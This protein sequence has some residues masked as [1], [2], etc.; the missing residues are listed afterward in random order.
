[1]TTKLCLVFLY[2]LPKFLLVFIAN[3][4]TDSFCFFF[5]F[6]GQN[7]YDPL[8]TI[9]FVNFYNCRWKQTH[10]MYVWGGI[11]V[12]LN[13]I[14]WICGMD[15]TLKMKHTDVKVLL[16]DHK[17]IHQQSVNIHRI[18]QKKKS[19]NTVIKIQKMPKFSH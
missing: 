7:T 3:I 12:R 9:M 17:Y 11:H 18:N 14:S 4:V 6:F 1:M 16:A 15:F 13:G 8:K 5:F 10:R 19:A 2:Y